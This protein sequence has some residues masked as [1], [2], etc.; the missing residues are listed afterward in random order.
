MDT[1]QPAHAINEMGNPTKGP[2]KEDEMPDIEGLHV[3][4]EVTEAAELATQ[5]HEQLYQAETQPQEEQ[6]VIEPAIEEAPAQQE[7]AQP[8]DGEEA[9]ERR[10]KTLEGKYKA[11]VPSMAKEIRRLKEELAAMQEPQ[12]EEAPAPTN[13]LEDILAKL[14]EEYPDELIENLRLLNRLEA[15]QITREA[16]RPLA[17]THASSEEQKYQARQDGFVDHISTAAPKWESI[18]N[19]ANELFAGDEPSDPAIAEFLQSSDPSGLYTNL[20]LLDMYNEKFD[21]DRF[22]KV[23]NLYET[24][25]AAPTNPSRDALLAPSRVTRQEAPASTE[26]KDWTMQEIA[27]FQADKRNEKY[28]EEQSAAIWEDIQKALAE[29]RIR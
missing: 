16:I 23:C 5:L 24:P 8:Q 6:Q 29:N 13:Q 1:V 14:K 12:K 9:Y 3:P 28:T 25:K 15:E 11:E 10:Y 18:W 26:A 21:S 20:D 4:S 27:Q 17:E 2:E 22:A 19:I 7:P